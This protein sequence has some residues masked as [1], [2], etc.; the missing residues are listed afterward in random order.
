SDADS[1]I[2]RCAKAMTVNEDRQP[3]SRG[4]TLMPSANDVLIAAVELVIAGAG[5]PKAAVIGDGHPAGTGF[6]AAPVT[7]PGHHALRSP[8]TRTESRVAS[9]T[10]QRKAPRLRADVPPG[11]IPG[12]VHG[13]DLRRMPAR[14]AERTFLM[15]ART[16]RPGFML[17][18]IHR[19]S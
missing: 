18:M 10:G 12:R 2:I 6:L 17:A 14:L 19:D 4:C 15:A 8:G 3:G 5:L 11:R 1:T 16:R 7:G 13:T 9:W